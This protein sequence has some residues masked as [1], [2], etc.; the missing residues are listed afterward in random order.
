MSNKK[1][2]LLTYEELYKIFQ[3]GYCTQEEF[4]LLSN[5]YIVKEIRF[6]IEDLESIKWY[7]IKDELENEYSIYVKDDI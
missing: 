6:V 5:S 1:K 3:R 7:I 2:F 4:N